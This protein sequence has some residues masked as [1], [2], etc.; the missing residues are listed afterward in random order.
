MRDFL[1]GNNIEEINM[2]FQRVQY[3]IYFLVQNIK[4]PKTIHQI[5]PKNSSTKG[6]EV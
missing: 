1:T 5:I 2:F 4:V 3:N 6:I